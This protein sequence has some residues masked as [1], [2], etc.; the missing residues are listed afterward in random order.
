MNLFGDYVLFLMKS[1]T[2]AITILIIFG[3]IAALRRKKQ[4]S[5][6]ITPLH[7]RHELLKK[8]MAH[9]IKQKKIKKNKK[10]KRLQKSQPILYVLDFQ[11]DIRASQVNSL[12]EEI[13]AILSIAEPNDE[14]VLRLESPGGAVNG[15]GLAASQLQRLREK[16]IPLTVCI[17]KMAASGG[18][19]MSS[20]ANR[21]IAAPFAIVGSIGVVAQ[22]PNFHQWLKKHSIDVELLTAGEYK[23]TLTVFGENTAQGRKKFQE[24]LEKI[25]IAF[26]KYVFENREELDIDKVSTGEHWLALDAYHLKL[27]DELKTSD[28]YLLQKME[29][30]QVFH[31]AKQTKPSLSEKFFKAASA[32][33]FHKWM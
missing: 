24:D 28:D 25:H 27:V 8:I 12:R 1:L 6:Q 19:L 15:Y 2:V 4:D 10:E 16:N 29:T 21:V 9:E 22:L 32:Y 14:V 20:I 30:H 13:T 23:R 33:L 7:E 3:G 5:F 18:Y 17:D 31:L 11:G 26:K